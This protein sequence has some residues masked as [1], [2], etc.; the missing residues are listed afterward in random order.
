M[1]AAALLLALMLG[2]ALGAIP[3]GPNPLAATGY[4]SEHENFLCSK[5]FGQNRTGDTYML[6]CKP[7]HEDWDSPFMNDEFVITAWW[8]P[9]MNVIHQ[10]ECAAICYQYCTS[11]PASPP[12]C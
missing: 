8:P 1:A 5:F 11:T 12:C 2:V 10:C 9:T 7:P 6:P 3:E 4:S